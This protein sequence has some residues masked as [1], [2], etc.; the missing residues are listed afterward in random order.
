MADPRK[1]YK[2]A[3]CN[4]KREVQQQSLGKRKG[5]LDNILSV[6]KLDVL[7]DV[8]YGKIGE[9]LRV[10]TKCSDSI[11]TGESVVPGREGQSTIN[12]TLSNILSA[13]NDD[14]GAGVVLDTTGQSE[15]YANTVQFHPSVANRAYGQAKSI[16]QKVKQGKFDIKDI[17]GVFS[18]LQNLDTLARGIFGTSNTDS[19]EMALCYASPYARD[20]IAFAPKFNFLFILQVKFS[21]GYGGLSEYGNDMAFVVKRSQR[22]GIEFEYEEINMYNFRTRVPK[23]TIFQPITMSFYDDNKNG[24]HTFYSEYL[25][26]MSPITNM[27][28]VPVPGTYEKNSM[29]F[30]ATPL[31]MNNIS[32]PGYASSLGPLNRSANGV[33]NTSIISEMK[34]FHVYDYG[35]KMNVY[36]FFNPRILSFTPSELTQAETGDGAEF[37]FQFAYDGMFIEPALSIEGKDS[38]ISG[39]SYD[40][41]ELTNN[42][43]KAIFPIKPIFNGSS[44]GKTPTKTDSWMDKATNA[45]DGIISSAKQTVSNAF[46]TASN[47]IGS[48]FS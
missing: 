2:I 3:Y 4:S 21:P 34:L 14:A 38:K 23:R 46:S 37:E 31:E 43:G 5:L 42:G 6:G 16:Y 20:L 15:N 48:K 22:P 13:N 36:T 7:N 47:F 40:I 17:P 27:A 29:N 26:A 18:D 8:G 10:L 11:R 32:V 41:T 33:Y 1:T 39:S 30:S 12:S 25:R 24:A 35:N 28:N 19:R 44:S 45:V 9:G